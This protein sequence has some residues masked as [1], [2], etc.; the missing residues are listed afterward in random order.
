M[1]KPEFI[2]ISYIETTPEELWEALTNS[3]FTMR[4]WVFRA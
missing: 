1:P 2:Y 3:E 4:Y